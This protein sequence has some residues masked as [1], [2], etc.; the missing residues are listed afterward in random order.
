MLRMW[1]SWWTESITLILCHQA[2]SDETWLSFC[3]VPQIVTKLIHH[4][5]NGS[6]PNSLSSVQVS[7]GKT[8]TVWVHENL[9]K[10]WRKEK[11]VEHMGAF[12]LP[13]ML[14][15]I[16]L[17]Y[18][19]FLFSLSPPPL[20]FAPPSASACLTDCI[21]GCCSRWPAEPLSF[22]LPSSSSSLF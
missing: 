9:R 12:L 20:S 4:W 1:L 22:C 16:W 15:F 7:L 3:F 8:W 5:R 14:S 19:S 2:F 11:H 6:V 17:H 18:V 21:M 13:I 10:R